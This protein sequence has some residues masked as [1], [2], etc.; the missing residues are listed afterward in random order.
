MGFWGDNGKDGKR[1]KVCQVVW[2]KLQSV[3]VSVQSFS[4]S[5]FLFKVSACLDFCS[6]LQ[7]VCASVQN[8]TF[9]GASSTFPRFIPVSPQKMFNL[10]INSIDGMS[11]NI[12]KYHFPK[13]S[14][15]SSFLRRKANSIIIIQAK[16]FNP[17]DN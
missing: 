13:A 12:A 17:P 7:S 4:L 10:S 6:K 2:M 15:S 11:L 16:F 3:W 8:F 5:G 9:S 14:S 1:R